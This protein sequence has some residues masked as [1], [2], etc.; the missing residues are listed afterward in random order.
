MVS[1]KNGGRAG[2]LLTRRRLL[3]AGGGVT[4]AGL[5]GCGTV[6]SYEFSAD[7]AVLPGDAR[8]RLDYRQALLEPVVEEHSRTV[9]GVEVDVVV[10]SYVAVYRGANAEVRGTA[11]APTVGA[12]ST[13]E[14]SVREESFNPLARRSPAELLT[15]DAGTRILARVGLDEVGHERAD[16]RWA[17]GPTLLDGREGECLDVRTTLE[18]YAGVLAGSPPSVA[19]VHLTRVEADSVVVVAAVHGR[20]VEDPDRAFVGPDA[21]LSRAALDGAVGVFA[22]ATDALTYRE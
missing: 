12:A 15:G 17:R 3:R 2:G 18:S 10:E 14:A 8:D 21:Y 9:D 6:T 19:F 11:A 5:A 4:A 1:E 22:A 20:D 16:L 7:P 13:P